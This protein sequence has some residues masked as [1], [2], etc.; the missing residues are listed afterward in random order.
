MI[1]VVPS[2]ESILKAVSSANS[3]AL[4]VNKKGLDSSQAFESTLKKVN[5]S[6]SNESSQAKTT[7]T[8]DVESSTTTTTTQA[9]PGEAPSKQDPLSDDATTLEAPAVSDLDTTL[10]LPYVT[11]PPVPMATLE[12]PVQ[13]EAVQ[14]EY[15]KSLPVLENISKPETALEL[16]PIENVDPTLV[17]EVVENIDPLLLQK[18]LEAV[19]L[20]SLSKSP[21]IASSA[22]EAPPKSFS[23]EDTVKE[24][25]LEA[26]KLLNLDAPTVVKDAPVLLN[27]NALEASLKAT[28]TTKTTQE[29]TETSLESRPLTEGSTLLEAS[30]D[31]RGDAPTDTPT[32]GETPS[33]EDKA[34]AKEER[35]ADLANTIQGIV[36]DKAFVKPLEGIVTEA[37][38]VQGI[39]PLTHQVA[40]GIQSAYDSANKTMQIQL[41]PEDLGHMRIQIKQVGEGQV[42]ARLVVERPEAVE[43][44]K[45]QLQ[46]LQRNLEQQGLKMDKIEVIL[47]GASNPTGSDTNKESNKDL[48]GQGRFEDSFNREGAFQQAS[49][50]DPA[51]RFQDELNALNPQVAPPLEGQAVQARLEELN[52]LRQSYQTYKQHSM[53]LPEAPKNKVFSTFNRTGLNVLA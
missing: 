49:Q 5:A 35:V 19:D 1:T 2:S 22:L 13:A 16:T 40:S 8:E 27:A 42:S 36:P 6:D 9:Q 29:P 39:Q 33:K 30:V 37:Q 21:N 12:V 47:A 44:V 23:I 26:S 50:E 25:V 48:T 4:L 45:T 32:Q 17:Q 18:T 11:L 24:K 3:E 38:G 51:Q 14:Q 41:N 28:D 52:V 43:Q 31:Q 34:P 53:S 15:P 7:P 20:K 46:D 10:A